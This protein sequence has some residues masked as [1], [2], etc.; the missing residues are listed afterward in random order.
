M[1]KLI[2]LICQPLPNL[3]DIFE[4]LTSFSQPSSHFQQLQKSGYKL[5]FVFGKHSREKT[6]YLYKCECSIKTVM[7]Q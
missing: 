5:Y 3:V 6:L 1:F 2:S 7:V 4:L